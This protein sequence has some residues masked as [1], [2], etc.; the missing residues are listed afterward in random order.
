MFRSYLLTTAHHLPQELRYMKSMLLMPSLH[1]P[2][3]SASDTMNTWPAESAI[4]ML[5]PASAI[6]RITTS[7][8]D[9]SRCMTL[10]LYVFSE[11]YRPLSSHSIF[12]A[13]SIGIS[14]TFLVDTS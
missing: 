14:Y 1:F 10:A 12:L 13:L 2:V 6:F 5:A 7:Y 11:I 9:I 4:K 8:P 3:R